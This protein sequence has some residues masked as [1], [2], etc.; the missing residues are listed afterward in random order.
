MTLRGINLPL[1]L[2]DGAG[3]AEMTGLPFSPRTA[4]NI[5]TEPA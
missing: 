5:G 4:P 3:A 2:G 1:P